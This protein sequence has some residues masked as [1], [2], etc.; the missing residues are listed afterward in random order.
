[1]TMPTTYPLMRPL[2][3]ALISQWA[4]LGSLA[5]AQQ[6]G[7]DTLVL[8]EPTLDIR[9]Y[10]IEGANPLSNDETGQL[11]RPFTGDKARLSQIEQA[12]LALEKALRGKGYIFHRVI[13]PVQ[14]PADGE[15]KLQIIRSAHL[16]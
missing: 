1:M 8:P 11:L 12:A 3:L 9:N 7:A 6:A 5:M 2:V 16:T 15:V 13:V 4:M 14:K 10:L